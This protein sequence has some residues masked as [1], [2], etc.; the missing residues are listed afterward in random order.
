MCA[1]Q[2]LAIVPVIAEPQYE[3]IGAGTFCTVRVCVIITLV[4]FFLTTSTGIS[5]SSKG[6]ELITIDRKFLS[7]MSITYLLT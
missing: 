5:T 7:L 2:C 6:R 4:L 1:Q 3:A